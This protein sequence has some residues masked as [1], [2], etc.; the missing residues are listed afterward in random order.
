MKAELTVNGVNLPLRPTFEVA[1]LKQ[2]FIKTAVYL[3][4]LLHGDISA[5]VFRIQ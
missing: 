4:W 1:V 2:A 3:V 5:A